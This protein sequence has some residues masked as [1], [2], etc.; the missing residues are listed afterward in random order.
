MQTAKAEGNRDEITELLR[1]SL[2]GV[3][4]KKVGFDVELEKKEVVGDIEDDGENENIETSRAIHTHILRNAFIDTNPLPGYRFSRPSLKYFLVESEGRQLLVPAGYS[5]VPYIQPGWACDTMTYSLVRVADAEKS[6]TI[7]SLKGVRASTVYDGYEKVAAGIRSCAYELP[8]Y[9]QLAGK[10][11]AY[12]SKNHTIEG[13]LE[14][15]L[16]G[17]M[18]LWEP[19]SR[20]YTIKGVEEVYDAFDDFEHENDLPILSVN[21]ISV[22]EAIKDAESIMQGRIDK[23]R[24]RCA[25]TGTFIFRVDEVSDKRG[26]LVYKRMQ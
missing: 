21:A 13:S 20:E 25:C 22:E 1:S 17:L 23:D 16:E 11:C 6:N 10:G 4:D 3:L 8:K 24:R 2:G 5:Y 26:N 19:Q 12:E 7:L 14:Q 18:P 15:L 9:P